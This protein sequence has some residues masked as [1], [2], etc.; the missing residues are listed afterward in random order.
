[1]RAGGKMFP[2][3]DDNELLRVFFNDFRSQIH[4]INRIKNW[5]SCGTSK[6]INQTHLTGEFHLNKL[7]WLIMLDIMLCVINNTG[8]LNDIWMRRVIVKL[9]D[10]WLLCMFHCSIVYSK[11]I[12]CLINCT[13]AVKSVENGKNHH[14]TT[15][16]PITHN[17][18]H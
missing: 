12:F 3:S 11:S 4:W 10:S 7:V 14:H 9:F 15:S 16:L 17:S 18:L 13:A 5:I 2:N 6:F 8:L 1:M